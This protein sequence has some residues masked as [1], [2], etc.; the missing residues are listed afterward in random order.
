MKKKYEQFKNRKPRNYYFLEDKINVGVFKAG[1]VRKFSFIL[2]RGFKVKDIRLN[3]KFLK[4]DFFDKDTGEMGF[5]HKIEP[6]NH[7]A[8]LTISKDYTM[9]YS[10]GI[11]VFL[12][13]VKNP[14]FLE[15]FAQTRR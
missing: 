1:I 9:V 13:G 7:S 5:S 12:E 14:V 2:R 8:V 11:Q 3:T 6:M 4:F 10:H 15:M